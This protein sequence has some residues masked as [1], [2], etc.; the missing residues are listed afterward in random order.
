MA[1]RRE[2]DQVRVAEM[3]RELDCGDMRMDK[4]IR[5]GKKGVPVNGDGP[6]PRPLKLVLESEDMKAKLLRR[7]KKL[8]ELEGGRMVEGVC[9]PG[10]DPNGE[11]REEGGVA[12]IEEQNG[13]R[14]E[15][16]G[17]DG[18]KGGG[19]GEWIGRGVKELSCICLNARSIMNKMDK[20]T[21]L[22]DVL[23]PD[24]VGITESWATRRWMEL[25]LE[26][27]DMCCSERIGQ[28]RWRGEVRE[29]CCM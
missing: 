3:F 1:G 20:F 27:T 11:G 18:G 6:R 19:G 13:G 28:V 4:V 10:F 9:S 26:W 21:V 23:R 24:V 12:G 16:F 29:F 25:N 22:M 7:A 15:E 5:L 8:K 17:V 2:A 14:R